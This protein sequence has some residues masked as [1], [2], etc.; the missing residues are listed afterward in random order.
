MWNRVS[1]GDLK[2]ESS[3]S[4]PSAKHQ[5]SQA[6]HPPP[7]VP[8]VET[9]LPPR[10]IVASQAHPPVSLQSAASKQTLQNPT[11]QP[12]EESKLGTLPADVC[13]RSLPCLPQEP[14]KFHFT[15]A[16]I[17]SRSPSTRGSSVWHRGI[18]K[19]RKKQRKPFAVFVERTYEFGKAKPRVP[20]GAGISERD[21]YP[22]INVARPLVESSTPRKRPLASPAERKWRAQTWKQPYDGIAIPTAGIASS[23][24]EPS[25][26]DFKASLSL[27]H[28][29]QEF[30]LEETQRT[31]GP[32]HLT[33]KRSPKIMPKPSKPCLVKKEA[34]TP[35]NSDKF[36]KDVLKLGEDEEDLDTF[37]IDVYVRQPKHLIADRA[38][39]STSLETA[40]PGKMGLLVI[41]DEDQETWELYGQE[42]QSS[43]DGWSSDEED[44]NGLFTPTN[45]PLL[46]FLAN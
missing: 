12:R 39:P 31:D 28:E 2:N 5:H 33:T 40:D 34:D 36:P 1:E 20:S 43:D 23:Q 41:E 42:E 4:S 14:R 38:M 26:D 8:T 9:T 46:F 17:S 13:H 24:V 37:V 32:R 19:N 22:N 44:E 3:Q 16:T 29:L 27:A 35:I 11:G 30:A 7:R 18:Q 45:K 15:P 21:N 10:D 25:D 6:A